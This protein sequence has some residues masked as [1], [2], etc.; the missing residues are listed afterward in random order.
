MKKIIFSILLYLFV[1]DISAQTFSYSGPAVS[2][3][4]NDAINGG[5]AEINVSGISP[6]SEVDYVTIN[7]T[8]PY[9]SDLRIVLEFFD[10]SWILSNQNG[11]DG[12]N[13]TNTVFR[14]GGYP[15]I[16]S[17]TAPFTGTF[18][19]QTPLPKFVDNFNPN[20]KWTL[21]VFDLSGTDIGTINN[22]S[23][24]FKAPA[25][26]TIGF[27]TLPATMNCNDAAVTLYAS[28]L[29]TA[30]GPDYPTMYFEFNIDAVLDPTT[31]D[32]TIICYEDGIQIFTYV[33]TTDRL[34][35]YYAGPSL[36]PAS[37]YTIYV[38]NTNSTTSWL[39]YDGNGETLG[40][41]ATTNTCN[42]YGP[43]SPHGTSSWTCTPT[44]GITGVGDWG[45]ALFDPS[46]V[47]AGTYTITY[48]WNNQ[49]TGVHACS[50]FGQHTVQINNPYSFTSLSYSSPVCKAT[51]GTISPV[52]NA[53]TGGSY[54]STSGLSINSSTGVINVAASTAGTYTVTY[55]AGTAPCGVSGNTTVTINPS[56]TSYNVTDGG[57]YCSSGDGVVVGLSNSQAGVNYQLQINSVNTGSPIAGTGSAISF[58]NQTT[59]GTYTVIATNATTG[60][61]GAMTGS[62]TISI[63][64]IPT[65]FNVT[66]GGS[67]CNGGS[68]VAVGL[69]SSQAGVN[70]QLQINSVNTGSP[71]SGTGSSISFG[72]QTTAGTYTVIATNVTTSCQSIMTGS[73]TIS[74]NPIPIAYSVTGGG[75]Y[76][77]GSSGIA[78]GL[79][80]SEIGIN[81]QLQINSVNTGSPVAGT[82][83]AINF[84]NQTTSGTYTV[85]ATNA[86]TSCQS[87]MTGSVIISVDPIPNAYSISG[88]GSYCSGGSGV[89]VG[90]SSSETGVN[91]QLQI[92]IINTG[93]PI[94]ATGSALSF[95]NQTTAGNYTVI[96]T[97]A[98]TGCQNTMTGSVTVT[99]NTNPTAEAGANTS[100][101]YGTSTILNG[102]A[103]GGSGSYSYSWSP[104]GLLTNAMVQ[105]PTTVS[106]TS[107]TV[108]TLTVTDVVTGCQGIDQVII[109]VTGGPLSVTATATP[110]S[111]CAGSTSQL[112]A[113]ASGGSS[114]F[115][116]LWSSNP[117]GLSS[118]LQNPIVS[119]VVTTIYTITVNDGF[120]NVTSS[121]TV[122]VNPIP[123]AYS[124]TGG[125]S[126]CSGGSGVAVGL[127]SS[128]TGVN[129]QLQINGVNSGSPLAGTSNAISFGN[130]IAAGNY[131]VTATNATTGCQNTMTG[132]VTIT[133]NTN[134]SANAGT[135]VTIPN[136]TSTTLNGSATGGSGSYVYSWSPSGLLINATVQNPTTVNLTSTTVFT[137]TVTDVVTGCQETDQIIITVTGGSLN[138]TTTATPTSL[139][140]GGSSQ[141]NALATNGSGTYT[142]SW[143]SN[144]L[145]FS[146]SQQN[147][148]VSPI[149]TT[150]YTVIVNDGFNSVTSSVTVMVNPL[151]TAYSVIGGGVY[152]SGGN[153]V[154]VGLSNSQPGVNYQ[155]QINGVN[156]ASP[157]AGTGITIIFG[158]QTTIGIYTVIATN[159]TTGC[160]N[161]MTG[162]VTVSQS[163]TIVAAISSSINDNCYAGHNGTATV[164]ATGGTGV[165]TYLWS[166]VPSQTTATA[167]NL[168]AGVYTVTVTDAVTCTSTVNVTITQPIQIFDTL[169]IVNVTCLNANDGSATI[170]VY[171]GTPPYSYLWSN[172]STGITVSNLSGDTLY[173]TVTD[174]NSC[175]F[176]DTVEIHESTDSL[177]ITVVPGIACGQNDGW[178][179]VH[180]AGGTSPFQILWSDQSADTTAEHL[181]AGLYH[182][183]VTDLYGCTV[184]DSVLISQAGTEITS[185]YSAS[186]TSCI[187][188]TDGSIII[189]VI[190]GAP[191]YVYVWSNGAT[192]K[193]LTGLI[194]NTYMVTITDILNCSV[195]D[196]VV[197]AHGTKTCLEVP[198]AFTPNADGNNDKWEF[199]NMDLYPKISVEVFN[200]WGALIF[201]SD[202]YLQEPWDGTYNGK[203]VP[204]GTFLYIVNQNNGKEPING[205]VTIIR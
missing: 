53:T 97:N 194:A 124:V 130:Q 108:F 142:Y 69:S 66:G 140:V 42:T 190:G 179:V 178:A 26:P 81:Y 85:I 87:T 127:S 138:A 164:I 61:Q 58:G 28:D 77:S 98:S 156:T 89:A 27:G 2:I 68:G 135:D 129:Y 123:T 38:C 16:T 86:T 169:D 24:T 126:Y 187:E 31:S 83:S 3:P 150:I 93:S 157:I 116:Y 59:A 64:P 103:T 198:S 11:L 171:G 139:C 23:I 29:A 168:A 57:S 143:S 202:K 195:V 40:S 163:P 182:V 133:I 119:P 34:T 35:V 45:A 193:D 49:G 114:T 177:N 200:R 10:N 185:T 176:I 107:T 121:V 161:S 197:V 174:Y 148:T 39:V 19:P 44:D 71:V 100:I 183:S 75:S 106:L 170:H 99:I 32:N 153:G 159:S 189:T 122:T 9:D 47:G 76:C 13:Y 175:T 90:L 146:S 118:S 56:P 131:T 20:G 55:T 37:A 88:G 62:V 51:G 78:V 145:G 36:S 92:N 132:S 125:G 6:V 15:S 17:G 74:V 7:L 65:A 33:V 155:L 115:T 84:G 12:D 60:C 199:K 191:P 50:G 25:C 111:L 204:A 109:S 43:W 167:I 136:G 30:G 82:G 141:L 46:V 113:L 134:P 203:D 1:S 128:D 52:L 110:T 173:I 158:N 147:P 54:T 4:D 101:P 70:Y 180:I 181:T 63:N 112:N 188:N 94:A 91:Y 162:S 154:A 186:P 166:T 79:S 95:G 102:S 18:V 137:L 184:I 117:P 144:P 22:W 120:N 80:S 72:N 5:W 149:T 67:Y 196:T 104:P 201:T 152:C 192:T 165:L 14:A 151:P 105:N 41:G 73:V 172:G 21:H 48:N 160:Q 8:H 205:T 96:A